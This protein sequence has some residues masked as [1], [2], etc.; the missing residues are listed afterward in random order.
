[1]LPYARAPVWLSYAAFVLVGVGAGVN[2]VLLPAQMA[3]YG[4]DRAAIGL[5]FF[6][7]PPGLHWPVSVPAR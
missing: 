7:G 5:T 2:G 4:V 1:M 6:T 3:R